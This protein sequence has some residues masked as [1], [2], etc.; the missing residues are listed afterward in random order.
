MCVCVMINRF[1]S[2]SQ[3]TNSASKQKMVKY[4][5]S[6]LNLLFYDEKLFLLC[7]QNSAWDFLCLAHSRAAQMRD[8]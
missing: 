7:L 1:D 3:P 4:I 5:E 2:L 8:K 6:M